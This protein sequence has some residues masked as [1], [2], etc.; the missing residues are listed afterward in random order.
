MYGQRW[1]NGQSFTVVVI[2]SIYLSTVKSVAGIVS[3]V[4][5]KTHI[6]SDLTSVDSLR[7]INILL[8]YLLTYLHDKG[9]RLIVS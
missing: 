3:I 4:N 6:A 1:A 5:I 9:L 7:V 8:T 2:K